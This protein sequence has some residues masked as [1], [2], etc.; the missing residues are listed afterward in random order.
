MTQQLIVSKHEYSYTIAS[1]FNGYEILLIIIIIT[2]LPPSRILNVMYHITVSVQS[3]MKVDDRV[4][5]F[6]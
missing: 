5:S 3:S 4:R 1:I 6:E 2:Y